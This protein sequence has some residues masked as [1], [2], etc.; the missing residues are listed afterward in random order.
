LA[1]LH[2]CTLPALAGYS[3]S[4]LEELAHLRPQQTRS[5]GRA[6]AVPI[7]CAG[8]E[9]F[10]EEKAVIIKEISSL[11]TSSSSRGT[12][13]TPGHMSPGAGRMSG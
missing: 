1:D 5:F 2:D 6:G 3:H 10:K 11:K 9:Q 4:D 13:P 8:D 7:L 12:S